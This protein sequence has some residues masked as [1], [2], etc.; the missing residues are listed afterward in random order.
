[1]TEPARHPS[2]ETISYEELGRAFVRLLLPADRLLATI[3]ALLGERI[4]IGPI[5]AGPG[6]AFAT[7]SVVG[8][9]RPTTG[10]EVPGRLLTYHVDLPI[11]VTFDLDL[12]M[13]R[14]RFNADLVVPLTLVVHAEAPARLR[15]EILVPDEDEIRLDLASAT[16]RGG[17]LGRITGMEAELRRFLVRALRTELDKPYVQRA[18]HLDLD[19]L[20]GDS[21]SH[22]AAQFLPAG[23]EDRTATG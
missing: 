8:L 20:V 12:R 4:E 19:R 2:R 11:D 5:G 1:M 16:R 17:V 13:D 21:W 18:T 7:V 23:P 6:R 14:M 9:F 10:H 15:I 3:D 22:I